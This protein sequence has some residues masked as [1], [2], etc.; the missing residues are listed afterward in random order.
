MSM[1]SGN[2]SDFELPLS[3]VVRTPT[4]GGAFWSGRGDV[5]LTPPP[6][7]GLPPLHRR[8]LPNS[9]VPTTA[10]S[11]P[12]GRGGRPRRRAVPEGHRPR[13]QPERE[14]DYLLPGCGP[15]NSS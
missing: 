10:G 4:G 9:T 14:R 8:R 5:P 11:G 1:P 12:T 2:F 3:A 6:P 7:G 15:T 13:R